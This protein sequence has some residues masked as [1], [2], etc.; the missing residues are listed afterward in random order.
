[1]L[2]C[3]QKHSYNHRSQWR[4]R[5]PTCNGTAASLQGGHCNDISAS[6]TNTRS[7]CQ[8]HS[9]FCTM[10]YYAVLCEAEQGLAYAIGTGCRDCFSYRWEDLKADTLMLQCLH[11]T[12]KPSCTICILAPIHRT[13]ANGISSCTELL[14]ALIIYNAGK[15]AVQSVPD[16]VIVSVLLIQVTWLC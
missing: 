8:L 14:G 4:A 9:T 12:G 3:N 1:M 15:G 5:P 11:L 7:P 2:T 6:F 16:L 10:Q 13:D